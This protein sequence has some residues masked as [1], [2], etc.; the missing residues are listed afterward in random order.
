MVASTAFA[1]RY[2]WSVYP[3]MPWSICAGTGGQLVPELGGQLHWNLHDFLIGKTKLV[4][5]QLG[6]V[7]HNEHSIFDRGRLI[8]LDE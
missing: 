2:R 8:A 6:Y 3:G 4:T 7:H 1:M 5:N